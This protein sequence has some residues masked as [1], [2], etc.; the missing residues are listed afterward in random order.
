MNNGK[1]HTEQYKKL[2]AEKF[3]RLYGPIEIHDKICKVCDKHFHWTG[4]KKTKAYENVKHCSRKCAN[5]IGG[6]RKA[7]LYHTDDVAHYTT[8]AWRH[9][10]KKCVVCDEENIV[11]VHHYD[12]NHNNNDPSNLIPLCPTHHQYMHSRYK[13]LVE[14][15]VAEYIK[16]R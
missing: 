6:K 10:E 2:Q 1:Y 15:Q 5:S 3:D 8:V 13:Y 9:H 11:T 7:N 4:R 16:G 12:E 14:E